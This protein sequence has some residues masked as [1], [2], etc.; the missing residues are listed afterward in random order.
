MPKGELMRSSYAI[1]ALAFV[2]AGAACT[3]EKPEPPM[4]LAA[5]TPM[6]GATALV[7]S[8]AAT[9]SSHVPMTAT[10]PAL[11]PSLATPAPTIPSAV[12]SVQYIQA[13]TDVNLRAGP[14][15]TYPII[16]K[17][18]MGQITSVTGVSLDKQWWRVVCPD[19]SVGNC[20]A[21]ADAKLT[22]PT[23][24][25]G[26]RPAAP[27]PTLIPALQTD[28]KYVMALAN[29]N[30]RSGPG[31]NYAQIGGM[32]PGQVSL[33]TG[34]SANKQWWRIVCPDASIGNCWL[35][36]DPKLTKPTSP[37]Q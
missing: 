15:T 23:T 20:W 19:D 29:V 7:T 11:T 6:V 37:P 16:G 12:T 5:P 21:S 14:A 4:P 35:S 3:K 13:L 22:K 26:A 25:P 24:A 28:V 2:F 36:A 31:T 33:V 9:P 1:V 10:H 27:T 34:I 8:A 18:A 32:S 17:V 30:I